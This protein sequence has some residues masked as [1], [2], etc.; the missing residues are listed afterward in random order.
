MPARAKEMRAN[1]PLVALGCASALFVTMRVSGADDAGVVDTHG[2]E[3]GRDAREPGRESLD[4]EQDP[5]EAPDAGASALPQHPSSSLS[6]SASSLMPRVR[7]EGGAVFVPAGVYTQGTESPKAPPYER[8]RR[9]VQ[10]A[11]FWIDRTEVSVG[12]YRA[13][14]NAG[15]CPR[16]RKSSL[17]CTYDRTDPQLPVTCVRWADA[18]QY[19]RYKQKRLPTEAEWEAAARGPHGDVGGGGC[20]AQVTLVSEST[21]RSCLGDAPGRVGTRAGGR[22]PMGVDDLRGNVEEWVEDYFQEV[23]GSGPPRAGSSHVLRG[24]GWLSPPSQARSY[25]RSWG[26]VIEAGPNVGFRCAKDA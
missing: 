12:D 2:H 23:R 14:V 18:V 15:A 13:C 21:A 8:P 25:S 6:P 20:Y 9:H 7:V 5:V 16:P 19:C 11:S 24:G 4:G 3:T 17:R 26:S 22:S 10:V 1:K